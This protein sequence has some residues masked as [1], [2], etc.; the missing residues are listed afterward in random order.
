MPKANKSPKPPAQSPGGGANAIPA[1][2]I[3]CREGFTRH[4]FI[5]REAHIA[6][7][8]DAAWSHVNGAASLVEALD[9]ALTEYFKRNHRAIKPHGKRTT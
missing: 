3:G 5:V 6:R 9:D 1:Q 2:K 4:T 7:L 8:H